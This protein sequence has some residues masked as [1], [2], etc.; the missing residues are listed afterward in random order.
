MDF[1]FSPEQEQLR[2]TVNRLIER[3]YEFNKHRRAIIHSPEGYSPNVWSS[4]AEIGVLGIGVDERHGGF[5]GDAIDTMIVMEALGR[6]LV[7]E[8][9][10]ATVVLGANLIQLAGS[11]A[12][13]SA[14]LPQ[15]VEGKL[16]L[17]FAHGEAGA[18]YD[19]KRVATLARKNGNGYV[20]SGEKI[21][22]LHGNI[23]DKIIVSA[24]TAGALDDSQ[25]MALFLVDAN[26]SG[27]NITGYRTIDNQRAANLHFDNVRVSADAML[28]GSDDNL[29]V[30][31]RVMDIATAA[32]VAESVGAMDALQRATL[33]FLKTRRQFGVPI[34]KF[35]ALQH[36]MVD[37][38]MSL[39]LSRSMAYLAAV[40][41]Q[42]NDVVERQRGVSA[43]K[44]AIG[45]NGRLI[46][47]EAVQMHGGM[48]ITDELSASHYF[49]R[50][51]AIDATLGDADHHLARFAASPMF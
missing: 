27:L 46:A 22:V 8:P 50:L 31:E 4:M 51:T 1:N 21:V 47:Q 16:K 3:E 7:V 5:G 12:Q 34:G 23:A 9:Y 38:L 45:R 36:R 28:G 43:A 33:E 29:A 11:D 44:N 30:V 10:L 25:G 15:V 13:K 39:E 41:V 20:L 6:G 18:R 32:L 49:R 35:Q 42:S 37:M 24:V 14:L 48:G 40:K 2:D 17:A 19:L 26:T